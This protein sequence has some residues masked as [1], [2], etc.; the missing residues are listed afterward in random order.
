MSGGIA[1]A[2]YLPIFALSYFQDLPERPSSP[3]YRRLS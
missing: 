2:I 3:K 1:F